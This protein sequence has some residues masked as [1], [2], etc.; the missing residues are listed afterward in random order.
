[1][2]SEGISIHFITKKKYIL[3]FEHLNGETNYIGYK[4]IN[5]FI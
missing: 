2:T 4:F 5:S 3:N 1:M